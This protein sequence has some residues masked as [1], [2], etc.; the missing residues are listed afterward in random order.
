MERLKEFKQDVK[1]PS[2]VSGAI[3][4]NNELAMIAFW[5]SV[6]TMYAGGVIFNYKKRM[7]ELA[8]LTGVTIKTTRKYIKKIL[9]ENLACED[10]GA[11]I[12]K[13][14][15][16]LLTRYS[17]NQRTNYIKYNSYLK[18]SV[19]E[20]KLCIRAQT[21]KDNQYKQRAYH[22]AR[23]ND[24]LKTV[25]KN[26]AVRTKKIQRA[27]DIQSFNQISDKVKQSQGT[28]A[29]MYGCRSKAT[30]H[31]W[32]GKLEKAGLISVRKH[33]PKLIMKGLGPSAFRQFK[34]SVPEFNGYCKKGKVYQYQPNEIRVN[35]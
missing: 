34:D 13:S 19:A 17:I 23:L 18:K 24:K 16:I 26:N 6:K 31:Y 33:T 29:R 2:Q 5:L 30:G 14:K 15:N 32:S 7:Q 8:K 12:L 28:I 21:I 22:A 20:I 11:L 27:V 3:I 35:F 1:V 25:A 4:Q 10:A 9:D